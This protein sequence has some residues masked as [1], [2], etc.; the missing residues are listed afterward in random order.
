MVLVSEWHFTK[1]LI[2]EKWYWKNPIKYG[3]KATEKN[4]Y[5]SGLLYVWFILDFYYKK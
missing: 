5:E 1:K 4:K 2:I 3:E